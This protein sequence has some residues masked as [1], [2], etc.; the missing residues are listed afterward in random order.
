MLGMLIYGVRNDSCN[1]EPTVPAVAVLS[2]HNHVYNPVA[3][4]HVVQ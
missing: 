1:T 4:F 2:P 3:G